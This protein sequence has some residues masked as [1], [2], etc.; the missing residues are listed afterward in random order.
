MTKRLLITTLIVALMI[1]V[2]STVAAANNGNPPTLECE[3]AGDYTFLVKFKN[4]G[5]DSTGDGSWYTIDDAASNY[6]GGSVV[7]TGVT[8][9]S[10]DKIRY[11]SWESTVNIAAVVV[12]GGNGT[13]DTDYFYFP[14]GLV[15]GTETGVVNNGNLLNNGGNVPAFSHITFCVNPDD[16]NPT[17]TDPTP[18]DPTPTDPTPTDEVTPEITPEPTGEVTPEPTDEVTPQV[19]PDVTQQVEPTDE[20]TPEVTPDPT[21][22]VDPTDESTPEVTPD[23]TQ[24]VE[25]TD[26]STPEL[27]PQLTPDPTEDNPVLT[28]PPTP[29]ITVEPEDGTDKS[30]GDNVQTIEIQ[31][32]TVEILSENGMRVLT[33]VDDGQARPTFEWLPGDSNPDRWYMIVVVDANDATVVSTWVNLADFCT[34]TLCRFTP[35]VSLLPEDTLLNG[36]YTW[37]MKAWVS[38][39]ESNW[40]TLAF[41]VNVPK[42]Q[43]PLISVQITD[44]RADISWQADENAA[45]YQVYV[46]T[47][48]NVQMYLAWHDD[49]ELCDNV[50]CKFSIG[51]AEGSYNVYIQ[52]WGPAGFS[53]NGISGWAGPVSFSL[54]KP[55]IATNLSAANGSLSWT[56]GAGAEFYDLW[57]GTAATFTTVHDRRYSAAE[58][59]CYDDGICGLTPPIGSGS[60]VWYVRSVNSAGF[61]SGGIEGWAEGP[62]FTR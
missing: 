27:T 34:D 45:W 7:I 12:K 13:A 39:A 23:P 5:E 24:E 59:A 61:S 49:N 25:P 30:S 62:A 41:T 29:D 17:P 48:N 57:I 19:T 51:L 56:H 2:A 4:G 15:N 14:G 1:A 46:G 3:N 18:T 8:G 10:S 37:W 60:Y 58:L 43:L 6:G 54:V 33:N 42:P 21:Q 36:N 11:V 22:E 9:N 50:S 55:S 32:N 35:D 47:E 38:G 53:D 16:Q 31:P 20:S 28:P 40:V 44:G 26:E 52:A